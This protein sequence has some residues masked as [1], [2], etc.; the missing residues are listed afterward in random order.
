MKPQRS[1]NF[2]PNQKIFV[3]VCKKQFHHRQT[4]NRHQR[5]CK[6]LT[7]K[8]K[9]HVCCECGKLFHRKDVLKKHVIKCVSSGG[10]NYSCKVCGKTFRSTYFV[11]RHMVK[12]SRVKYNCKFC[13]KSYKIR[14]RMDSHQLL[15]H[16]GC[17]IQICTVLSVSALE[18]RLFL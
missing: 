9:S 16:Q 13:P 11:R 17:D 15:T 1:N 10:K 2:S 14:E 3:C 8:R 18:L 12:H 5:T 6:S 4:I 7:P